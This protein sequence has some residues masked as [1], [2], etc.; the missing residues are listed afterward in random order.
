[1]KG[2]DGTLISAGPMCGSA[3]DMEMLI[4]AVQSN[5]PWLKDPTLVPLPLVVPDISQ[6]KLRVGIMPH[7]GVVLPHPPVLRGL[8]L[9]KA[10]LEASKEVE[11][12]EYAPYKHKEGYGIIVC[13]SKVQFLVRIHP[14]GIVSARFS[15]TMVGRRSA[16]ALK[17]GEK[18]FCL[19]LNG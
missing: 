13:R 11:V 19:W 14:R 15:L 2:N 4:K 5:R 16:N 8:S 3:R 7:D 18:T 9:A 1:M 10:K 6:K 12:V 17:T